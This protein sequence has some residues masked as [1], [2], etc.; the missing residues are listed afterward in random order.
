MAIDELKLLR[1]DNLQVNNKLI[2]KNPTLNEIVDF[3]E[4]KYLNAVHTIIRKPHNLMV[5]LYDMGADYEQ[6]DDFELFMMMY[7]NNPNK[8]DFKFLLGDYNFEVLKVNGFRV[9]RVR[10]IPLEPQA[11]NTEVEE[12]HTIES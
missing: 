5:E 7:M 8:D 9:V 11:N 12:E 6:V 10:A 3:G 4:L 2:I 1:G